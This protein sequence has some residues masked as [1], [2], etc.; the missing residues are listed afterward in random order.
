MCRAGEWVGDASHVADWL[1][2]QDIDIY[3]LQYNISININRDLLIGVLAKIGMCHLACCF[4][5]LRIRTTLRISHPE[6][7]LILS[8][9]F[10]VLTGL[11]FL[12][13]GLLQLRLI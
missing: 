7:H 2:R 12:P 6:K 8:C 5:T 11:F 4:S 10:F 13:C 9:D 1:Q 3:F